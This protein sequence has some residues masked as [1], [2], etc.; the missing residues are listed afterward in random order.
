MLALFLL[1]QSD[2]VQCRK[3]TRV[4]ETPIKPSSEEE[5]MCKSVAKDKENENER[6]MSECQKIQHI[7]SQ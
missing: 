6:K 5:E 3:H 7:K 4:K 2:A 1:L